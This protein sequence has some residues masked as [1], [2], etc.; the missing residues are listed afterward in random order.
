MFPKISVAAC[1]GLVMFNAAR[2]AD[3]AVMVLDLGRL[4][5]SAV[6]HVA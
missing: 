4:V 3:V 1:G 6:L 2:I 5:L